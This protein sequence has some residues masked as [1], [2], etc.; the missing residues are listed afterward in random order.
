MEPA[1]IFPRV[2]CGVDG[3]VESL[4]AVRQAAV[5]G[6]GAMTLV[7]VGEPSNE[8]TA[9]VGRS[10]AEGLEAAILAARQV[11]AASGVT[12]VDGRVL[13]GS[14]RHCLVQEAERLGADLLAVGTR[15]A[16]RAV[17]I[18]L[19]HVSTFA[20]HRAPCSV[21]VVR[22]RPDDG[23]APASVVV[24]VD[25]SAASVLACAVARA[26]AA[27]VD[28][29]LRAVV[30]ARDRSA[31]LAAAR[32]AAAPGPLETRDERPLRALLA[33]ASPSTLL[34]VGDSGRSAVSAL[35][36]VGEQLVHAAPCSVLVVR[37]GAAG[38]AAWPER[39]D[40]GAVM[41]PAGPVVA[42]GEPV[43]AVVGHMLE[44]DLEAVAIV[45]DD[46][47]LCGILT[48]SD[49]VGRCI[50]HGWAHN[51]LPPQP[52]IFRDLQLDDTLERIYA[53]NRTRPVGEI[54]STPVVVATEDELVHHVVERMLRH[55]I[56]Q[57]PVVRDG[58]PV[59]MLARRDLLPLAMRVWSSAPGPGSH[60][61]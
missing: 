11:A 43:E 15:G 41:H 21:L 50:V 10:E 61:G 28:V 37:P 19:G 36:S 3:S 58:I 22:A 1:A 55:A 57:V 8:P 40:V 51:A 59:G 16:G 53:R 49:F 7:A 34:V 26:V 31:D 18:A 39:V 9:P 2:V 45:G 38:T 33:A 44:H 14:A 29:G 5:A 60:A 47:R 35:G 30:G 52:R 54:M 32:D 4:E 13:H 6:A 46:R 42:Q 20:V 48:A 56:H 17:G 24:G 12:E 25:G 23:A 27:R